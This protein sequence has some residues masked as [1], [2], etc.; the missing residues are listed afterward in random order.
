MSD[1]YQGQTLQSKI[2]LAGIIAEVKRIN[3]KLKVEKM[4]R[5]NP[6]LTYQQASAIVK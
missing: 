3:R 1:Q 4:V 5:E 6:G 2:T